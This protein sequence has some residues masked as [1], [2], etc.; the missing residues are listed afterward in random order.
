MSV[1]LVIQLLLLVLVLVLLLVLS[2]VLVMVYVMNALEG[3]ALEGLLLDICRSP[4]RSRSG[5]HMGLGNVKI[6]SSEV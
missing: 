6:V 3:L 5:S 2:L 1:K 4:Q